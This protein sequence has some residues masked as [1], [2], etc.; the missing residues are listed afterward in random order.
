M[1]R[2][3]PTRNLA[4][5][6]LTLVY[7]VNFVDRQLIGILAEPIRQ[8]L[9]LSDRQLGLLGG[10]AFALFYTIL[11]V[12]IARIAERRGRVAIIAGSLA[13]WSLMTALTGFAHT[14]AQLLLARMGVGIG[15]AGCSP[16]AQS[17]IADLYPPDRRATALSLYSLGV[18]LGMVFGALAGG[19]L[20]QTLGWRTAFVILGLPGIALAGI[21][22]LVLREPARGRFD[23]A[24]FRA[25]PVEA[26]PPLSAILRTLAGSPAFR[27][28]AAG[29][30]I[31]SF[32]GYGLTSFAVPLM[33]R[34]YGLTLAQA[35]TGFGLIVGTA[36]G[37][38]IGGGGWLADRLRPRHPAAPGLVSGIGVAL[39]AILFPVALGQADV[40]LVALV[41]FVPFVC[42]HL[43]FGPTYA[44]TVNSVG[45][46]E[47]ATAVAVL[48][49]LMNAIG[50]GLGPLAVGIAS[51]H[52][53]AA[54]LPGYAA[55][56]LTPVKAP[57]CHAASAHGLAQALRLDVLV[58]FWAA[59]HFLLAGRA[60]AYPHSTAR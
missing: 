11:G 3:A 30:S 21:V 23:P 40:R 48:L 24:P 14:Y 10:L 59:A 13:L 25:A 7:G 29:A 54:E 15:E 45:P 37:I 60:L 16:S 28:M 8:E 19:W 32:A 43:Y 35:A 36:I 49:L 2:A 20:A 41:A 34:T 51:D 58:Y 57:A 4:L 46:A 42:A 22:R 47:R 44:V 50:L 5:A 18:P 27:H 52:F 31:A 9:G 38:G 39:A 1:K 12:P 26:R 6:L 56:C 17:L 33:I 53:A 55:H